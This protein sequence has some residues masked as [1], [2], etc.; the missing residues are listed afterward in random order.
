M[1]RLGTED[2]ATIDYSIIN[3]TQKILNSKKTL[4]DTDLFNGHLLSLILNILK[5]F[6]DKDV[7]V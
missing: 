5:V 1:Q 3:F 4:L 6:G 7:L 2:C